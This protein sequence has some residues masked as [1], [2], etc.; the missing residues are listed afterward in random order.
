[1]Q[2]AAGALLS[3]RGINPQELSEQ[4]AEDVR[5]GK[6]TMD[7]VFGGAQP[8]VGTMFYEDAGLVS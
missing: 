3:G 2:L 5:T 1:M 8:G 7:D 6:K 4:V